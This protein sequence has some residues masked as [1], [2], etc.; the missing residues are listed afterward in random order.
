VVVIQILLIL[1]VVGRMPGTILVPLW[2]VDWL[3]VVDADA[4]VG[5][6]E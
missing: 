2:E 4:G 5:F 1:V 6:G 3:G